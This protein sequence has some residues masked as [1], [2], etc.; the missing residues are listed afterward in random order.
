MQLNYQKYGECCF[1]V[2]DERRPMN[3]W[4]LG[5]IMGIGK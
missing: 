2:V 5:G 4:H 1:V 3:R